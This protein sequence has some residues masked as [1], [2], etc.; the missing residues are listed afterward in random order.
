[1]K[2]KRKQLYEVLTWDIEKQKFTPHKGVRR[3]PYT[4]FGLRK[5]IRRLRDKGYIGRKGDP[6]IY[7]NS[8]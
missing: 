4:L 1:M 8:W 7:V 6:S 3:G 5:A 2:R